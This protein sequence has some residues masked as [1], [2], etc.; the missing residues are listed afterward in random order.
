M[1]YLV[2]SVMLGEILLGDSV[3]PDYV[4]QSS[5]RVED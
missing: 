5:I 4:S 2:D 3:T 1:A